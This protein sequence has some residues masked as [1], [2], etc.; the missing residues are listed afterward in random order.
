MK[1]KK[2]K[3]GYEVK[4]LNTESKKIKPVKSGKKIDTVRA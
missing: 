2:V 4:I 3:N 1:D